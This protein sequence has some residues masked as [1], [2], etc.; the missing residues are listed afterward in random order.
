MCRIGVDP[1]PLSL[2]QV[3]V[4]KPSFRNNSAI[5]CANGFQVLVVIA[6]SN[7]QRLREFWSHMEIDR[8]SEQMFAAPMHAVNTLNAKI[9]VN[10]GS[11]LGCFPR[12]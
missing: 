12:I 6:V 11:L 4:V 7:I 5:F 8:C 9:Q 1:N 3:H 2:L 10:V